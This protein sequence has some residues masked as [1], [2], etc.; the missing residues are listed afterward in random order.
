MQAGGAR[1]TAGPLYICSLVVPA[2]ELGR[3]PTTCELVDA[4][5]S[6]A[7]R[8]PKEQ[9]ACHP[10]QVSRTRAK[11]SHWLSVDNVGAGLPALPKKLVE[12]IQTNKYR[13]CSPT[14]V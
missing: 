9:K 10:G 11:V 4:N 5:P 14:L 2:G 13:Y 8:I 12:Q 7:V 1:L 6:I 3:L